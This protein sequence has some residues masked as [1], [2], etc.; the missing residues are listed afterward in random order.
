M[1]TEEQKRYLANVNIITGTA[2]SFYENGRLVG[3]GGIRHIGVGEAWMITPPD[4]R[5]K[6]SLS[7]FRK[8]KE[9]FTKTRDDL[10]LWRCFAESKISDNFLNHLGFEPNPK[11]LVWTRT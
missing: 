10:N 3:V 6:R 7:L 4:V 2:E 8:T 1:L 5:G 9:T 11:G